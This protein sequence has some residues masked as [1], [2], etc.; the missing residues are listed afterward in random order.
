MLSRSASRTRCRIT[1]LA[2][3][4]S[5]RPN[6]WGGS[7]CSSSSPTSAAGLRAFA[8][9]RAT[10][11]EGSSTSWTTFFRP[12]TRRAP[13]LRSSSMRTLSGVF[14]EA[15]RRAD[16]S[17]SKRI[18]GLSPFSRPICSI[19]VISSRFTLS[20][21]SPRPRYLDVEASL[22]QCRTGNFHA[23]PRVLQHQALIRHLNQT[24]GELLSPR[25]PASHRLAERPAELSLLAEDSIQAG[26]GHLQVVGPIDHS[27]HVQDIP[28]F[29]TH[30]L[31]VGHSYTA[32]LVDEHPDHTTRTGASAVEID[33]FQ[34]ML[35]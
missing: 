4:A 3:C 23:L 15:D 12:Y 18:S 35:A 28:E 19:T 26:R 30:P 31:A 13:V 34:A 7:S 20:S 16:S 21:R 29:P 33:Q 32:R 25:D 10:S 22:G 14:L 17:A 24:P 1:C 9:A 6:C 8:S 27:R 5:M 11:T 2:R